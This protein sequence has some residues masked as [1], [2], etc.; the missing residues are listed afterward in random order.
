MQVVDSETFERITAKAQEADR[1]Y[2][3]SRGKNLTL[4]EK[5]DLQRKAKAALNEAR[6]LALMK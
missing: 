5:I 2:R 1:L 3:K 6:D 4:A